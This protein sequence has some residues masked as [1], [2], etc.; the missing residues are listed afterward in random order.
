MKV[1]FT[2]IKISTK[3][4]TLWVRGKKT[5][6]FALIGQKEPWTQDAP[7]RP[8]RGS[9]QGT[10]GWGKDLHHQKAK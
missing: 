6:G 9:A 10:R 5:G 8:G 1:I 2:S 7:L 4:T 3:I